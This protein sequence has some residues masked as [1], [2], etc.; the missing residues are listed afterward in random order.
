MVARSRRWQGGAVTPLANTGPHPLSRITMRIACPDC[1]AAYDVP[2]AQLAPGRLTRCARC[3]AVWAPVAT[4]DA[5]PPIPAEVIEPRP[6]TI[7]TPEPPPLPRGPLPEPVPEPAPEPAAVPS[8]LPDHGQIVPPL[9]GEPRF[10]DAPDP[11]PAAPV[12]APVPP[13]RRRGVPVL[14]GWMLTLA[15]L[16]GLALLATNRRDAIIA[17][18]PPS[19]RAYRVLG[20][21]P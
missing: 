8:L 3:G 12:P 2:P 16:L 13:P 19:E 17:A 18:W 5:S 20:L 9:P 4:E 21:I 14:V 10:D 11:V 6:P 7:P 1:N 15:L